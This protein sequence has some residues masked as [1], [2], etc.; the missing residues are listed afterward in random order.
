MYGL[1]SDVSL[2][3]LH[4][5]EL[6][7]ILVG[8]YQ[9]I[10]RFDG[11]VSISIEGTFDHRRGARSLLTATELPAA[12]CTLLPLIGHSIK[13]A[14]NVGGGEIRLDFSNEETVCLMDSNKDTESYQIDGPGKQLIV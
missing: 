1:D 10:L 5:R 8:A 3:F 11:D 9:L 14:E 7:Q 6:I 12:A 4:G 13:T 2:T